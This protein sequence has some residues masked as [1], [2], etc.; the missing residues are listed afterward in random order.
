MPLPAAKMWLALALAVTGIAAL[1]ACTSAR[2]GLAIPSAIAQS[3]ATWSAFRPVQSGADTSVPEEPGVSATAASLA[4]TAA[5]SPVQ[6]SG[7][8]SV[9]SSAAIDATVASAPVSVS[10]SAPAPVALGANETPIGVWRGRL[11]TVA[12]TGNDAS[13]Q[14]EVSSLD[15]KGARSTLASINDLVP[16]RYRSNVDS[17]A[18][19]I[20][21]LSGI[22]GPTEIVVGDFLYVLA[23]QYHASSG[24]T[25]PSTKLAAEVLNLANPEA[26]AK[27]AQIALPADSNVTFITGA[28]ARMYASGGDLVV[29]LATGKFSALVLTY[30]GHSVDKV[31]GVT[32]DGRPIWT[33]SSSYGSFHS[34]K[35]NISSTDD[36]GGYSVGGTV[37]DSSRYVGLAVGS[38]STSAPEFY[39]DIWTMATGQKI[40]AKL[41]ETRGNFVP[42]ISSNGK[43]GIYGNSAFVSSGK[44]YSYPD[45]TSQTGVA[46]WAIT[47]SGIAYGDTAILNLQT[48]K[49]TVGPT[50]D[51]E[52]QK[53]NPTVYGRFW[54]NSPDR[55][56]WYDGV[57]IQA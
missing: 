49:L 4:A 9:P 42:S 1:T 51:P 16:Y 44:V 27:I 53:I 6:S 36:L 10:V 43:Y 33:D 5:S 47:D 13:V 21:G 31:I 25:K 39:Q 54:V 2:S 23:V 11:V 17:D 46:F 24:L 30:K 32:V 38:L 15:S 14:Y 12:A 48:G 28:G 18:P 37:D 35:V 52:G 22:N 55:T 20:P 40:A 41:H 7:A 50:A 8:P 57:R 19:N 26:K 3:D 45:S 29:D 56:L 34:T